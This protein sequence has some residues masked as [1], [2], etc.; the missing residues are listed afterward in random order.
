MTNKDFDDLASRPEFPKKEAEALCKGT[1]KYWTDHKDAL[2]ALRAKL[3]KER[4]AKPRDPK[5]YTAT[6][7]NP[8][9]QSRMTDLLGKVPP[10]GKYDPAKIGEYMAAF[11]KEV[12]TDP[13]ATFSVSATFDGSS[14]NLTGE[15]SD[16]TYHDRL[17]DLLVAMQ[18]FNIAN[19][20][21]LPKAPR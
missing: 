11:R 4:A 9:Y 16:R 19:E 3:A 14:I 13:K 18:F 15:V 10:G 20:I 21:K 12:V 2:V 5:S 6:T 17:I 8:E 1:V 7:L